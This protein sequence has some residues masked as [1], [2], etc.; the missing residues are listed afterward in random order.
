MQTN[1]IEQIIRK[2]PALG[3]IG[4][5][6]SYSLH[7]AVLN[8]SEQVRTLAD[9][10]HGTWLKHP[11]HPVLTDVTLGAWMFGGV[12][13]LL[14]FVTHS[15]RATDAADTLTAL[16]TA[17]AVPTA[18]AGLADFSTLKEDAMEEG[19]LHGL[20]NM[21]VFLL[22]V[23]SSSARL[24]GK[25]ARG[26]FLSGLGLGIG[27]FSAWLGGELVYKRR[28]GVNHSTPV[29]TN[30]S[31]L[32]VL[33]AAELAEHETKRVDVN[34]T[35]IVLY[36]YGGTVYAFGA[37]CSHAGGP[38]EK[39]T[40]HGYSVQ[41]PWHD[42][43]FDVRDGCVLHGPATQDQPTIEVRVQNGQIEVFA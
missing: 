16:G 8:G 24:K 2:L 10:L 5:T 19:T 41:C 39:G 17:S 28:V 21:F 34:G 11:L 12:F 22:F 42:S 13:D 1:Q 26:V 38:L 23:L 27:A 20:T 37:V 15:K 18:L 25:R 36:R 9:F 7:R 40:Y 32:A 30:E 6:V 3:W 4:K 31:W 43:V 33:P 35:P 29:S 14:G